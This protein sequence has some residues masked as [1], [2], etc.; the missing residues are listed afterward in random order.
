MESSVC[1][2]KMVP[3]GPQYRQL[4]DLPVRLKRKRRLDFHVRS[5]LGSLY[6]LS[7]V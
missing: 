1:E 4:S 3:S 5:V 7:P 2:H 6:K